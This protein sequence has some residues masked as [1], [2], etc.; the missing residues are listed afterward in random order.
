[1]VVTVEVL[2]LWAWWWRS[3]VDAWWLWAWRRGGMEV[4]T[5]GGGGQVVR[6]YVACRL[7]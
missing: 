4:L 5:H 7:F 2:K 3:G 1:M 6:S